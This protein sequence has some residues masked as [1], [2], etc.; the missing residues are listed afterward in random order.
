MSKV[1]TGQS[2]FIKLRNKSLVKQIQRL[3][4]ESHT[5]PATWVSELCENFILEHRC[6]KFTPDPDRFTERHD[7]FDNGEYNCDVYAEGDEP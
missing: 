5:D 1:Q 4:R 2:E 7:S 3:A 6:G